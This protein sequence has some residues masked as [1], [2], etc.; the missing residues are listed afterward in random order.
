[1]QL[2][3]LESGTHLTVGDE[4]KPIQ[5]QDIK[6]V[7]G[8]AILE[9]D[10][11]N[12]V[13][14]YPQLINYGDI[15]QS[16]E[17]ELLIISR[18]TRTETNKTSDLLALHSD[19][20]LVVVELKR[21]AKD[22]KARREELEFQAIRYAAA[23]SKLSVDDVIRRCSLWL[24]K[25]DHQNIVD[26]Y[27]D[28]EE[29]KYRKIAVNKICQHLADSDEDLEESD[30]PTR[31]Q[32]SE[33]E[34]IYLVA[35]DFDEDVTSACA[36]LRGYGV[37]IS[38][39][40]LRPYFIAQTYVLQRERLIPPPELDEFLVGTK[41]QPVRR[42]SGGSNGGR[43]RSIKPVRML[44]GEGDEKE[45]FECSSWKALL[46]KSVTKALGAG[47]PIEKL[48]MN[49]RTS[50]GRIDDLA[51]DNRPIFLEKYQVYIN[52]KAGAS[53]IESWIG[54]MR[55]SLGKPRGFISVEL[56]DGSV[57]EP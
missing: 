18:E 36:W 24:W 50:D 13:V 57:I 46:E 1:M 45:I 42:A 32:P 15:A 27:T 29:A 23:H 10:L 47:L 44:W 35:G 6:K 3:R 4:I 38:C 43:A 39:F 5:L 7:G 8:E 9:K 55:E 34:R 21:D 51:P 49:K 12:L 37:D 40:R 31:I 41:D 52:S 17:P 28:D 2:F 16:D 48:P 20:T 19:G 33:N 53:A 25:N 54:E 30:L 14:Q 22:E 11:V 26:G 56:A